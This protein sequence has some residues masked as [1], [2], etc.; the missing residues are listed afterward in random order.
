ME[1]LQKLVD[2]YK[3]QLAFGAKEFNKIYDENEKLKL[4]FTSVKTK[5]DMIE[6]AGSTLKAEKEDV[7]NNLSQLRLRSKFQ[8]NQLQK[9]LT[10][11]KDGKSSTTG[12]RD[13]PE[14]AT[15]TDQTQI[16]DDLN[17][18]IG[19]LESKLHQYELDSLTIPVVVSPNAVESTLQEPAIPAVV[20][21]VESAINIAKIGATM[22]QAIT[23]IVQTLH[24]DAPVDD[25]SDP[26]QLADTLIQL[27]QSSS[28]SE[29][30]AV[31]NMQLVGAANG[32][33]MKRRQNSQSES[34]RI[35]LEAVIAVLK[36]SH[37]AKVANLVAEK[38]E[39]VRPL[40]E[41]IKRLQGEV[42]A[43][44]VQLDLLRS[45]VKDTATEVSVPQTIQK[46]ISQSQVL[47]KAPS[48]SEFNS[49][50]ELEKTRY[51]DLAKQFEKMQHEHMEGSDSNQ[52]Q[53]KDFKLQIASRQAEITALQKQIATLTEESEAKDGKLKKFK[54][55]LLAANNNISE[56]KKLMGEKDSQI[57]TLNEAAQTFTARQ[58]ELEGQMTH[59]QS[60]VA[61]LTQEIKNFEE[62][63][64][65]HTEDL[66]KQ[67]Q[68]LETQISDSQI[69]FQN[70]RARAQII[71]KDN[72]VSTYEKRIEGLESTISS[73][74]D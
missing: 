10:T 32:S 46:S 30:N 1:K 33:V 6:K 50:L 8:I 58:T 51:A 72:G 53:V 15:P 19:Q 55:L 71:L 59:L 28:P 65:A 60:T 68:V 64:T 52:D 66:K 44:Q 45:D 70:Y 24:S 13:L 57:A 56:T 74:N 61:E 36:D 5:C 25:T 3:N 20:T 42:E 27:L 35:E 9:E 4:E 14:P 47:Q 26:N 29:L 18:K 54:G 39:A 41:E 40:K 16:I 12:F 17:F 62:G 69:E 22:K 38:D 34:R 21:V 23:F 7:E 2:K 48:Q 43:L 63:K 49:L 11:F 37:D 73:T 67:I 31:E